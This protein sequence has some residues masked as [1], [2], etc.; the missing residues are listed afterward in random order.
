MASNSRMSSDREQTIDDND[1]QDPRA[2]LIGDSDREAFD[3]D[4]TSNILGVSTTS[5]LTLFS[6]YAILVG[7]QIGSGIFSS[8]SQVDKN[9]PSPGAALLVW[10]CGGLLAWTG[11]ASFAEL[12]ACIPVNGGMQEYLEYIYGDFLASVMSWIWIV[13]VK[14]SS[15][16]ILSIIFAEY[17]MGINSMKAQNGWTTKLIALGALGVLLLA[18]CISSSFSTGLTRFLFYTKLLTVCFLVLL[19]FLVLAVELNKDGKGVSHDWR[20]KPWFSH[21]SGNDSDS[22]L[23]WDVMSSWDMLGYYTTALYAGLWAYSGWDSANLVAGE[24]RNTARDL[25]R[26]IHFAIPTVIVAFLLANLSYYLILPWNSIH[27]SDAIAVAV[28][29]KTLGSSGGVMFALLVSASCLGSLN[30]NIFITGRLTVASAQHGYIP[31]IFVMAQEEHTQHSKDLSNKFLFSKLIQ[32]LSTSTALLMRTRSSLDAPVKAMVFNSLLAAIFIV[33]GTFGG[34]VT[35]IGLAEYLFY[36]LTVLG[37]LTLRFTKPQLVRPYQP[38][39]I[40]PIIFCSVSSFLVIRGLIHSP[41][42]GAVLV[43]LIGLGIVLHLYKHDYFEIWATKR[44]HLSDASSAVTL[45]QPS[46]RPILQAP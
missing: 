5:Q 19:T 46:S 42:Q 7:G 6:A 10:L 3:Q 30:I 8:P 11:A 43:V 16:A 37:G 33:V 28:G 20:T 36:F 41:A 9:V 14:P 32:R 34:L 12:G 38:N 23:K 2:A 17:W 18:N 35:F 29:K 45:E 40:V 26:A 27:D 25:P 31:R 4:T 21:Q 44:R 15:M 22:D 1:F 39:I 24:M 13:A